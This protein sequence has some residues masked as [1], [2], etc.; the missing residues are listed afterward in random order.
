MQYEIW[1]TEDDQFCGDF[2]VTLANREEK[3]LKLIKQEFGVDT[4]YYLGS[5]MEVNSLM[6]SIEWSINQDYRMAKQ[7][8]SK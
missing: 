1:A 5:I 7:I 8:R 6:A 4:M 2:V 3:A